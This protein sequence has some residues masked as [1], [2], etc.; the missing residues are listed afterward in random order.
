MIAAQ[1]RGI[2]TLVAGQPP[3]IF[4]RIDI[5]RLYRKVQS[6]SAHALFHIHVD[7]KERLPEELVRAFEAACFVRDDF[8]VLG[9]HVDCLPNAPSPINH[10]TWK[11]SQ[12]AAFAE[13]WRGADQLLVEHG[14]CAYLEGEVVALDAVLDARVPKEFNARAFD[15]YCPRLHPNDARASFD[16]PILG[17]NG[18]VIGTE[19]RLLRARAEKRPLN[20]EGELIAGT[21]PR[22]TSKDLFRASEVH[23]TV[24]RNGLDPR[25]HALL[26]ATGLSDPIIPKV[27]ASETGDLVKDVGGEIMIIEDMPMTLQASRKTA[28]AAIAFLDLVIKRVLFEIG[29]VGD[30]GIPDVERVSVKYEPAPVFGLYNGRFEDGSIRRLFDPRTDEP[31]VLDRIVDEDGQ[32]LNSD[33]LREFGADINALGGERILIPAELLPEKPAGFFRQ[34][35]RDS[36]WTR[37]WRVAD[38]PL[39]T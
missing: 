15:E 1:K 20:P 10:V 36:Q 34:L 16:C 22:S 32:E 14:V 33:S 11:G 18:L 7:A 37:A 12:S 8:L 17:A 6:P 39:L 4:S 28:V 23:L 5:D 19:R 25:V 26:V 29:G 30:A 21:C 3:T 31:M 2:V 27:L 35:M 9:P 38:L 13:A 24:R